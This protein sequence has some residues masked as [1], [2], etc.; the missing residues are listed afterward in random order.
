MDEGGFLPPSA[1]AQALGTLKSWVHHRP[2]HLDSSL[3]FACTPVPSFFSVPLSPL[4]LCPGLG[5]S[6]ASLTSLPSVSGAV[7]IFCGVGQ[8]RGSGDKTGVPKC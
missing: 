4:T 6:P 5:P 1:W 8:C 2:V 7:L 3:V